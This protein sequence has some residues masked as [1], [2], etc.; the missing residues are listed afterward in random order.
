MRELVRITAPE[1]LIPLHLLRSSMAS[2]SICYRSGKAAQRFEISSAQDAA[3]NA[4]D[5]FLPV[6]HGSD[7]FGIPGGDFTAVA[8]FVQP[9]S[10]DFGVTTSVDPCR[11]FNGSWFQAP[12]GLT[13][14]RCTDI[15]S[16][17]AP[18]IA[19]LVVK[20]FLLLAA[21]SVGGRKYFTR[22]QLK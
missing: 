12:S 8:P 11:P 5:M 10:I 1:W 17:F 9:A 15:P 2:K 18:Q 21:Q 3:H 19:E 22:S 13:S 4:T 20:N 16:N 6:P 7:G 14:H